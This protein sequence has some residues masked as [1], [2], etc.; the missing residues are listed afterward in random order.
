MLNYA[1][2]I[3]RFL[4]LFDI[5]AQSIFFR[6]VYVLNDVNQYLPSWE[7]PLSNNSGDNKKLK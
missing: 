4:I 5:Y 7:I 6:I 3:G 1:D 2:G